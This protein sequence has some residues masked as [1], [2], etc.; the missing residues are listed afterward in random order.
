MEV[1][2]AARDRVLTERERELFASQQEASEKEAEILSLKAKLEK[3][4]ND[5]Q[6]KEKLIN[7]WKHSNEKIRDQAK[8]EK[9]LATSEWKSELEVPKTSYRSIVN[10]IFQRFKERLHT[11]EA[12]TLDWQRKWETLK[13]TVLDRD[14]Q[15]ADLENK[16]SKL[17]EEIIAK[18]NI[19]PFRIIANNSSTVSTYRER[20]QIECRQS[21]RAIE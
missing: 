5:L 11:Q 14:I 3:S 21:A 16:I 1:E 18:D 10:N 7:E 4:L 2:V 20:P 17:K 15:I 9:D 13:T 19:R 8:S 12:Q 6:N